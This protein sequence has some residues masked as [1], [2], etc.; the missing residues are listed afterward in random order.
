M[1]S[2]KAPA[3]RAQASTR[4]LD[5]SKHK[6]RL[7]LM[8]VPQ[9]LAEHWKTAGSGVPLGSVVL[10]ANSG[11]GS[12]STS[13]G[14]GPS[15][16]ESFTLRL[17]DE[18]GYP[19]ELPREYAINL[20]SPPG[21]MYVV[22]SGGDAGGGKVECPPALEGK[23][24][25]KGEVLAGKL[26]HSYKQLVA[27]RTERAAIRPEV[28]IYEETGDELGKIQPIAKKKRLADVQDGRGQDKKPKMSM[29]S[30]KQTHLTAVLEEIAER[31]RFG[32]NKGEYQ[33]KS[34]Y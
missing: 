24:E 25:R 30:K 33:L 29:V 17:S 12:S 11:S 19:S 16:G 8:K 10:D 6:E 15:Q 18:A 20:G 3:A 5:M 23:V 32:K 4:Q 22:S 7:W 9:F 27:A 31:V 1:A 34:E 26:S 14:G 2:A 13:S 28:Q 21:A